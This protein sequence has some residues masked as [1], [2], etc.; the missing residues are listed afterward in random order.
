[1]SAVTASP[2]SVKSGAQ[3]SF[4]AFHDSDSIR[5]Y[6]GTSDRTWK[7]STGVFRSRLALIETS[8]SIRTRSESFV[9][10]MS[11]MALDPKPG[12]RNGTIMAVPTAATAT[13]LAPLLAV[14]ESRAREPGPVQTGPQPCTRL[15][16]SAKMMASAAARNVTPYSGLMNSSR[17]VSA[18]A[19][20]TT[21]GSSARSGLPA[22][23]ASA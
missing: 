10:L 22:R 9:A 11:K 19:T 21:G 17:T 20:I 15:S 6:A 13:R 23:N 8:G 3:F 14:A 4:S 12:T 16:A 1:M 18:N 2:G 7:T 5:Q